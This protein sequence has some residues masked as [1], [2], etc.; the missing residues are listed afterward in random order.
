MLNP[1]GKLIIGNFVQ[2]TEDIGWKRFTEIIMDWRL[3]YRTMEEMENLSE[4]IE[5]NQIEFRKVFT[6]KN[7]HIAFTEIAKIKK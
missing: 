1:G 4:K 2:N 7:K 5:K 6:E 3:V